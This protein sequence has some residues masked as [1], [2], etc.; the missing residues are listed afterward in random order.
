MNDRTRALVCITTACVA[1][2]LA[3][4]LASADPADG[5][6]DEAG[7][8]GVLESD[9][10]WFEKQ[11]AC[12]ALRQIGTAEAVPALAAL[13]PLQD[14]SHLARYALE[15]MPYPE[16]GQALRDA[17][18]KTTGMSQTGVIISIGAR[19]DPQAVPLL[20][21]LLHGEDLD[22]ARAT[23][24]ALG[25]IATPDAV[26]ALREFEQDAPEALR[27]AL[28]EGL[29]AAAQRLTQDGNGELAVAIYDSLLLS[30]SGW[31]MAVRMGAF[32]GRAY[33][34]PGQ[35]SGF[36][37][38]AMLGD[39]PL[40]RDMAAQIIAET[41]GE[42]TTKFYAEAV[43]KVPVDGQVALLRGLADRGDLAARPA[44][45][46]ALGTA[47]KRVKLAAVKA[48]GSIGGA[49]D[50][51]ALAALL[52]LEDA[53]IA[54][55]AKAS[56]TLMQGEGVD[57]AIADAF[58]SVPPAAR[59]QLLALLTNRRAEQ[60][61]SLAVRCLGDA[62]TSVR[63]AALRA[64]VPLGSTQEAPVVI[65]AVKGAADSSE[66]NAA[67]KALV[68]IAARHGD[69]TLPLVLAAMKDT[70]PEARL[71]LLR[72]LARI[73]APEALEAVLEAL[74][75]ARTQISDEAVRL[76][77]DWPTLAAAPHLL[78]LA[79]SDD[80]SRHVLGLRGYVRLARLEPSAEQK[81]HM[82]TTAI[83]LAQRPDEKKR[84]L[85][86]WGTL[87]TEQSL[88]VLLPH[89]EDE[90]VRDEAALAIIQVA[91]ELGKSNQPRAVDALEAV[92]DKC[93]DGRIRRGARRTLRRLQ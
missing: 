83:A 13:L 90:T 91:G 17:L 3:G 35:T 40:F 18:D 56:L 5:A 45:A 89:L 81:T 80:L 28:A 32:R 20:A 84:V 88:E 38:A 59:A 53:D 43:A 48:L 37:L 65:A 2:L 27:P 93:E 71:V 52:A 46:Q 1:L 72:A 77:S 23:A 57:T 22:I 63:I 68:A 11:A 55:A 7:L 16:A 21:P 24:G 58:P 51:A 64:L 61:V 6:L 4:G 12:R 26:E 39:E 67:Q 42:K 8:I 60:T 9:A 69:E 78:E 10:D 87:P 41:S 29:L 44:V 50:V 34:R 79:Q 76:L 75:D 54:E 19:R 73:G 66:R 25:R 33:A 74:D 62:D 82:L 49:G 36:V 31:P 85:A 30:A 86:A 70:G 47:D 92:L 15:A 14:L